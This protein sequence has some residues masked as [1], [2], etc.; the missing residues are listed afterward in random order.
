[1]GDYPARSP[2]KLGNSKPQ[3]VLAADALIKMGTTWADQAV[4]P[5]DARYYIYAN[6]PPHKKGRGPAGG[7]E[8][9]ADGSAAWRTFDSWYRLT[10]WAGAYGQTFVYWSQ[11]TEDFNPTLQTVLPSLK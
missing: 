6:C 9:F 7:N 2:I 10:S 8:V 1:L 4:S 5:A 3:W 11:E